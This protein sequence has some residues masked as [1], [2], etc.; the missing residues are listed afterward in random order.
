M[1][2]FFFF[3]FFCFVFVFLFSRNMQ[4]NL[5]TK[6][7]LFISPWPVRIAFLTTCV[8]G[9]CTGNFLIRARDCDV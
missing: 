1:F 6:K 4:F 8:I 5:Q 9:S 3:V 2:F 7:K